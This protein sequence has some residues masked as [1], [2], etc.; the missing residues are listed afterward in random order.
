[1]SGHQLLS[2]EKVGLI[3]QEQF[4][5]EDL[6]LHKALRWGIGFALAGDGSLPD[7]AWLPSGRV[8]YW[9]GW[10]GSVAIMD[11]DRRVTLAFT[12]NKMADVA[13]ANDTA[14]ECVKMVYDVLSTAI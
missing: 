11:L 10:G 1:M 14:R 5:G 6:V 7:D 13:M 2:K 9:G 8:C 4:Q 12:M 3:F